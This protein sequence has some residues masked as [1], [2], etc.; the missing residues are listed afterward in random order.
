MNPKTSWNKKIQLS[1]WIQRKCMNMFPQKKILFLCVCVGVPLSPR[2]KTLLLLHH[3][4]SHSMSHNAWACHHVSVVIFQ[5]ELKKEQRYVDLASSE[6]RERHGRLW[7]L[8][9]EKKIMR[10]L[11]WRKNPTRRLELWI[12]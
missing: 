7:D 5:F 1:V 2:Q 11:K 10:R 6:R 12:S 9:K 4:K 3:S 8:E